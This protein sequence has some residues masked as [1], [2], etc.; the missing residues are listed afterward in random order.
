MTV[1]DH[2]PLH[3]HLA[4]LGV[5]AFALLLTASAISTHRFLQQNCGI[6]KRETAFIS[7][8]ALAWGLYGLS[9]ML[10]LPLPGPLALG[11]LA[12][13]LAVAVA[14]VLP[15]LPDRRRDYLLR[16]AVALI[17][18]VFLLG[19][20]SQGL[21]LF[22]AALLLGTR[23]LLDTG[24]RR[25]YVL[26]GGAIFLAAALSA[27]FG[28]PTLITLLQVALLAM[29][30]AYIWHLAGLSGRLLRV[31]LFSFA[32][33]AGLLSLAGVIMVNNEADF[34]AKLLQDALAR[35]ELTKNRIE[36]THAHA[37]HLLKMAATDR[38]ALEAL[39]RPEL[40]H[41]IEFRLLNRRIGADLSML[42][43]REGKVIATSDPATREIDYEFRP[44]FRRALAGDANQYM[45]RSLSRGFARTCFARAMLNEAAEIGAVLVT[46]FNLEALIADNVRMDGVIL[47]RQGAVLFG[48]APYARGALFLLGDAAKPLLAERLFEQQDLKH[49]GLHKIDK[50]WVRDARGR[51]WIW[52]SVPLPDNTWEV[53][54]LVPLDALLVYRQGQLMLTMLF[55]AILLLLVVQ[56]LQ[57]GN[58]VTRLLQEVDR[59]REAET[60]ERLARAEVE[61]QRDHL[62]EM[63][64]VR[65]HD[66][67]LAKEAAETANRA[68]STF[69]ANMSHEL[70]TP[71]NGILGM[72][73]LARSRM[74]DAKGLDQLDKARKAADHLLAI[75]NDILDLSKIEAERLTLES[76]PLQL[77]TVFENLQSL[78]AHKAAEK[79][80]PLRFG[81]PP[82]LAQRR[83]L[84]DPLRLGQI[85]INLLGNAIKF[86]EKGEILVQAQL[87]SEDPDSLFLRLE[88]R[89]QGVGISPGDQARL[90]KAFEQADGSMTRKYGG[91]GLGLTICKRL[92]HMMSGDIGVLSS[93]GAGSVF[94]LT[95][96]LTK[97]VS[98]AS[99]PDEWAELLQAEQDL[100]QEFEGARILVVEDE[101]VNREVV[102]LQLEDT[103]LTIDLAEDGLQAVALAK[104]TPYA[105]ILMDVQMPRLNGLDATRFI[106]A[107]S[108]NQAT[109]IVAMTA[110]AYLQDRELCL[111]AGMNDHL[112]KPVE[113]ERLYQTLLHWLRATSQTA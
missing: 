56:F 102:F 91:T 70:R 78:F 64:Q 21:P 26:A 48:P 57:N 47:H 9:G 35:L 20:G 67:A 74:S 13:I 11:D 94:W 109:P 49:L 40:N 86:S 81:L 55:I 82:D 107:D 111:E 46:C 7:L 101:L 106:R 31:L 69:L 33:L 27:S 16:A 104:S 100:R 84:G 63:V 87:L 60:S 98:A 62:E 92:T 28:Q 19:L 23:G 39:E 25:V 93:P 24:P 77:S 105:L 79:N 34:R 43:N 14:W 66:L 72:I 29:L 83:L 99:A 88:V 73:G 3:P 30:T 4:A 61:R 17:I 53:S 54:K 71:F 51:L 89:D 65:T 96:R 42:L 36:N 22:L 110:N 41:D 112:A 45:A 8:H 113:P 44:Y 59:R 97:D 90:F 68:K 58:F 75:I 15:A 103:G 108:L 1:T 12:A 85:L 50:Y 52:A 18:L 95:V 38:V 32:L 10:G 37:S 5:M 76:I 80:L 6:T 2:L